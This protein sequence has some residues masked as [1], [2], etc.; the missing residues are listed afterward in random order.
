MV[1]HGAG[2][3]PAGVAKA[4]PGGLR[5]RRSAGL[6]S[7]HE[8][9]ELREDSLLKVGFCSY[10]SLCSD[11]AAKYS[12]SLMHARNLSA[13]SRDSRRFYNGT[14]QQSMGCSSSLLCSLFSWWW[15]C[16]MHTTH[17]GK[18][19]SRDGRRWVLVS[20]HGRTS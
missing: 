13:Q 6:D 9:E 7:I 20:S 4:G 15:V 14:L 11:M 12:L 3:A 17:A 18:S 19:F 1:N 2:R 16:S 10:D 5:R 8:D